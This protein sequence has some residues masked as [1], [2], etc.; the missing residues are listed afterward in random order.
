MNPF[1]DAEILF[2]NPA[3]YE[4]VIIRKYVTSII[5]G[6]FIVFVFKDDTTVSYHRDDIHEIMEMTHEINTKPHEE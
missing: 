5:N 4:P 2:R 6:P 1:Y 3:K